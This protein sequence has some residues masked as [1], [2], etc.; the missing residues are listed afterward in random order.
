[1]PSFRMFR[2]DGRNILRPDPM[3]INDLGGLAIIIT[4][5]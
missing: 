1:M 5:F 3:P 4:Q 2:L